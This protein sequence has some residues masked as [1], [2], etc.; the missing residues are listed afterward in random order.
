[1]TLA[2]P[3]HVTTVELETALGAIHDSPKDFGVLEMIVRRPAVGEREVVQSGELHPLVGLVGDS[4][5]RRGSRRSADGGPHPEMQLNIMN[6]RVVALV[7]QAKDRWPLAG[8]NC[9]ST[10]ISSADNLP[11][12]ARLQLGGAVIEVTAE[13]HTGGGKFIE[14]SASTRRVRQR[15]GAS[16]PAPARHQREGRAARRHRRRRLADEDLIWGSPTLIRGWREPRPAVRRQARA[17]HQSG[18]CQAQSGISLARARTR[19]APTVISSPVRLG[20]RRHDVEQIPHRQIH[21]ERCS[22]QF[23]ST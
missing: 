9:S 13:P 21:V 7:A 11:P 19:L 17:W 10:W 12:G 5:S 2:M 4:W 23:A 1:M 14:R 20:F 22:P 15:D 8:A 3:R 18:T 6:A 16:R